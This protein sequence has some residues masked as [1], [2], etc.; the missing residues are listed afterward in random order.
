MGKRHSSRQDV[1]ILT[2]TGDI[3]DQRL[4]LD[5]E[6]GY[7]A[8]PDTLE[9]W[10]LDFNQQCINIKNGRFCQVISNRHKKPLK[11]FKNRQVLQGSTTDVLAS[12]KEDEELAFMN[13]RREKNKMLLWAG[14][15]AVLFAVVISIVVLV[16]LQKKP[17]PAVYSIPITFLAL[18]VPALFKKMPVPVVFKRRKRGIETTEG[19]GELIDSD[20]EGFTKCLVIVEKTGEKTYPSIKNSLIPADSLERN[21]HRKPSHLLGL[22]LKGILWAIEPENEIRINESPKDC[23][24]ALQCEKEVNATYS[25]RE[26]IFEKIKIGI[27]IALCIVELIVLFLIITVAAGGAA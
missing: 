10:E 5:S 14:I 13:T 17:E 11:I 1:C 15:I 9:A 24:I 6:E 27:F 19:L 22:D 26:V 20:M 12:R 3:V 23:F 4:E 16:Q 25:L 18:A 7:V 8:S 21:Y 2:E